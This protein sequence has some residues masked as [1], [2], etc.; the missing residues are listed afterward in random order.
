MYKRFW[1]H[2]SQYN[3]YKKT[4]KKCTRS[5]VIFEAGD[6]YIELIENYPC[7]DKGE[8]NRREGQFIRKHKDI[9]CNR[10]VAGRSEKEFYQDNKAKIKEYYAE[11]NQKNKDKINKRA[12]GY[13]QK[14]KD[15]IAL[16]RKV[17]APCPHCGKIMRKSSIAAHIRKN[18]KKV[19]K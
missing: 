2:K 10:K 14:N 18:C 5:C 17:K 3:A 4:G 13:Y 15:K 16:Q 19:P 1:A 9:C 12:G 6:P 8:L 7:N 11:Y